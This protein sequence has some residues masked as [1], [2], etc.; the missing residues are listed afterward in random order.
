M[1]KL[2]QF[3][4]EK[5]G[6][7]LIGVAIL[8]LFQTCGSFFSKSN[9][10]YS[11]EQIEQI[12]KRTELLEKQVCKMATKEDLEQTAIFIL[13]SEK[14]LDKNSLNQETLDKLLNLKSNCE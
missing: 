8:L 6:L 12:G 3:V 4:E 13:L 9:N 14:S 2:N 11:I 5:K 7:I 1:E 10:T